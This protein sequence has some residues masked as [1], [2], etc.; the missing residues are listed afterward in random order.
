MLKS[1]GFASLRRVSQ[2]HKAGCVPR[3]P[4]FKK[5]LMEGESRRARR[6][7]GAHEEEGALMSSGDVWTCPEMSRGNV[8][9]LFVS[10]EDGGDTRH[11]HAVHVKAV[12]I[13]R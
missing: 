10:L 8:F 11:V 13:S 5:G 3:R 1:V 7:R 9:V 2:T 4:W 12:P 6:P